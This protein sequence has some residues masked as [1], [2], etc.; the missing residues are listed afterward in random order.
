MPGSYCNGVGTVEIWWV[1]QWI[2]GRDYDT[3]L[4]AVLCTTTRLH[5]VCVCVRGGGGGGMSVRG[6]CA[7]YKTACSALYNTTMNAISQN[8]PAKKVI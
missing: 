1:C 2:V 3:S 4:S 7:I 8:S 5:C 6:V